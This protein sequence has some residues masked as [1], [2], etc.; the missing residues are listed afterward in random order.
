MCVHILAKACVAFNPS[1]L[2]KIKDF[3]RLQAVTYTVKV[4]V[5][6]TWCKTDTLLLQ[7]TNKKYHIAYRFVPFPMISN[8]LECHW[9]LA[10]LFKCNS[11]NIYA[12]VL[13]RFHMTQ[14]VARSL[15]D[16]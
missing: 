10:G 2:S 14:R 5:S 3:S 11:T 4:V 9:S 12:T 16:S 7:P 15:G 1:C 13:A 8:D 6:Q